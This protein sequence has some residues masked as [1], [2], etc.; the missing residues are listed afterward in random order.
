MISNSLILQPQFLAK[1][2]V[3]VFIKILF[4]SEFSFCKVISQLSF[5]WSIWEGNNEHIQK[6]KLKIN[7]V[8]NQHPL[9]SQF[10]KELF[11]WLLT[12]GCLS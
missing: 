8:K 11:Y 12:S 7:T 6:E 9:F 5:L 10:S 4:I 2:I 1:S 3:L